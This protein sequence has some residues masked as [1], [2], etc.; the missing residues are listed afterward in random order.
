MNK[1]LL[2][3]I[4]RRLKLRNI[5]LKN[6]III[7]GDSKFEKTYF[8]LVIFGKSIL[9]NS[10]FAKVFFQNFQFRQNI[11]YKYKIKINNKI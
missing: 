11:L 2:L 7:K 8:E 1:N 6:G 4:L 5:I 3:N 10:N 9:E